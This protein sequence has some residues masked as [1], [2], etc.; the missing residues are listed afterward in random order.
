MQLPLGACA[1]IRP[2]KPKMI[3]VRGN[4][5]RLTSQ[6]RVR[7]RQHADYILGRQRLSGFARH[8]EG[9]KVAIVAKRS[10]CQWRKTEALETLRDV[11]C[12]GIKAAA[13]GP[14][15]LAFGRRQPFDIG[16]HTLD[17]ELQA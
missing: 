15:P 2:A 7:A 1:R 8:G 4:D 3:V 12:C 9:L 17:V 6:S 16:P 5:Q 10:G 13:A 11:G 14:P